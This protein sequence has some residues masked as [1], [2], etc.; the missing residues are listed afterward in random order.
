MVSC[1][2]EIM[3]DDFIRELT[4]RFRPLPAHKKLVDTF[5]SKKFPIT[6]GGIRK[7]PLAA[8][9][10]DLFRYSK[11]SFLVVLP[12]E[13]E[14]ELFYD[15]IAMGL[16]YPYDINA[17]GKTGALFTEYAFVCG[18][19]NMARLSCVWRVVLCLY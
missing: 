12:N 11:G 15:D 2:C 13:K 3:I 14:A 10:A 4:T 8:V 1:S 5:C 9:L 16:V 17:I 18:V 19:H 6:I 7:L